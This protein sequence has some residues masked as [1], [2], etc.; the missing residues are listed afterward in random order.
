[1]LKPTLMAAVPVRIDLL[2]LSSKVSPPTV[3]KAAYVGLSIF[4]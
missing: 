2:M 4:P 1:M 3:D